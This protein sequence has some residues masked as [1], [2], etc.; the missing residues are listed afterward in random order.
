MSADDGQKLITDKDKKKS[1][2]DILVP[3][4]WTGTV[5]AQSTAVVDSEFDDIFKP[6]TDK[7]TAGNM[8]EKLTQQSR[9]LI[10]IKPYFYKIASVLP[11]K[12]ALQLYRT[13]NATIN[14]EEKNPKKMSK[15]FNCSIVLK[16]VSKKKT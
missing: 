6:F 1:E 16:N 7:Y 8:V 11:L 12:H 4:N 5:P 2:E 14:Q 9:D 3:E 10:K 15:I 13:L